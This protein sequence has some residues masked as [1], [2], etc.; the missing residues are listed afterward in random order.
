MEAL[1]KKKYENKEDTTMTKDRRTKAELLNELES[2][3]QEIKSLKE[4]LVRS[5]NQ[6]LGVTTGRELNDMIEGLVDGGLSRQEA[7][8]ALTS[9]LI[10]MSVIK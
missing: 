10:P 8:M 3:Q 6:E 1:E 7:L 4:Q 5:E 2:K 9:I